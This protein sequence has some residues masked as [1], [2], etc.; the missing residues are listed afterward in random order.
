MDLLLVEDNPADAFLV[1]A[2]LAPFLAQGTLQLRTVTDGAQALAFL[3]HYA[4][5][6][7]VAAP[8][9][10]FLDLHMPGTSGYEVLA[11][12]HQDLALRAIPVVV[13]TSSENPRDMSQC[14]ELG[15]STYLVKPIELEEFLTLVKNTVVFWS[16][17]KFRTR[18]D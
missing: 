10:V 7:Q 16:G 2:A 4:P 15:A 18:K 5:Y 1:R 3:R 14:Y 12:L 11:E 13:L 8:D 17:C 9:L 6:T